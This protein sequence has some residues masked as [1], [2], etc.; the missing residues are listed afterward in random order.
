[1]VSCNVSDAFAQRC[2]NIPLCPHSSCRGGWGAIRLPQSGSAHPIAVSR[3]MYTTLLQAGRQVIWSHAVAYHNEVIMI[4]SL[5][6]SYE[7]QM[8]LYP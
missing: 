8:K 2:P 1:M 5:K 3:A 7:T 6:D 4:P